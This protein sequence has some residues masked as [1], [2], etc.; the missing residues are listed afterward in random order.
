MPE[1]L[2]DTIRAR[3]EAA[4]RAGKAAGTASCRGIATEHGVSPG[5][6][7]NI[8][9]AAGI[10]DPFSRAKTAH[11]TRAR[12]TDMAARRAALA[13]ALLSKAEHILARLD[14]PYTVLVPTGDGVFTRIL[15]EPPLKEVK[16]GMSAVALA[17][18]GHCDLIKFDTK[19]VANPAASSLVDRLADLLQ[20]D[21]GNDEVVDDGYPTP[22]AD[23]PAEDDDEDLDGYVA[24]D[25]DE[26]S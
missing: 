14:Q 1:R 13:E 7:R 24:P 19:E 22:L 4:I 2:D 11:A 6:V 21:Q 12:V 23:P 15:D 9:K 8:A 5:T 3:I 17:V 18:K 10:A 26:T 25:M 16:D 20:L